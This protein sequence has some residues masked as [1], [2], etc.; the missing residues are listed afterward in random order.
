MERGHKKNFPIVA[1]TASRWEM[2]LHHVPLNKSLGWFE[3]CKGAVLRSGWTDRELLIVEV[4][5]YGVIW[6]EFIGYLCCFIAQATSYALQ[7]KGAL[8]SNTDLS[9]NMY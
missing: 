3:R 4:R 5:K 2:N 7:Y 8:Y 6:A 9:L 1:F